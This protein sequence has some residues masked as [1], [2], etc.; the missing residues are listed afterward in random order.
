MSE[1]S[2]AKNKGEVLAIRVLPCTCQYPYQD[3]K[4]GKGKRWH[5]PC[6]D[7]RWRCTVCAS[8]KGKT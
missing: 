8:L 7:G 3:Q 5:N 4:L 6:K 2:K 1:K